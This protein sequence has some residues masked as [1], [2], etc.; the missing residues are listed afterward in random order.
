[1]QGVDAY[2]VRQ[3][4]DR[5]EESYVEN[6]DYRKV[7]RG[8]LNAVRVLAE[9]PK[10]AK[11]FPSLANEDAKKQFLSAIDECLRQAETADQ[12]TYQDLMIAL[13][14]ILRSDRQTVNLPV[15]VIDVEFADGMTEQLDR[16]TQLIWPDEAAEF[17][18]HTMGSFFGVGIQI[19]MENDTLK[20]I[21]PM[22][23]APAYRAGIQAGDY[24]VKIDGESAIGMDIDEA[25]RKITGPKGTKVVLTIKRP[26]REPFD[27]VLVREEVRV[28]TVKGWQRTDGAKWDWMIDEPNKIGYL[29]VTNFNEDTIDDLRAALKE[30]AAKGVRGVILDLRY[31]PGGLLNQAI[32]MADEFVRDGKIVTTRGRQQLERSEGRSSAK[33]NYMD[34]PLVVLV[35]DVSASASEIVAGALKDLGRATIV[36]KRTFGKGVVQTLHNLRPD[37]ILKVT[38][39]YYYL[40][41]GRCLHR[42][43]GA[44]QWGVEPDIQVIMTP[45]QL[46]RW[47]TIRR[48]TEIL[49]E[50]APQDIAKQ[51]AQQL[52][53]DFQL[54]T[55]LL[56]CRLQSVQKEVASPALVATTAPTT[57]QVAK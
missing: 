35:N 1:M 27:K 15:E 20:V 41:S 2:S 29:R 11:T 38:T 40:P 21:S 30:L 4:I 28:Q 25:V 14:T 12:V 33:G 5:I 56:I 53:D 7:L 43:E 10:V 34:G 51:M 57:A 23:D 9:S 16:Y 37:T 13:N 6:V 48:N 54:E 22:E 32:W 42:T 45:R 39:A 3:A 17:K 36:G 18:K 24:I 49:R 19:Q 44:K 50:H 31:D 55:A 26:G 8:A 52:A 47:L 46:R